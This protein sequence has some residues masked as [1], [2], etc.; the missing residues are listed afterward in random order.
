MKLTESQEVKIVFLILI[1]WVLFWMWV[2][3]EILN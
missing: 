3:N 1:G 2:L